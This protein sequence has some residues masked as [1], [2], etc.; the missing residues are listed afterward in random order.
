[1]KTH[2]KYPTR[3]APQ[4]ISKIIEVDSKIIN[5][6]TFFPG[7]MLGS[8]LLVTNISKSEQILDIQIDSENEK[9]YVDQIRNEFKIG[10]L[11]Y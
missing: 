7:K 11:P 4:D 2:K 1:L 5:F 3:A 8:T 6:S 10:E 9:Y